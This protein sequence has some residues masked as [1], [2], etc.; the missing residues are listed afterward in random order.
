MQTRKKPT[1]ETASAP[2]RAA[3]KA[4]AKKE[5]SLKAVTGSGKINVDLSPNPAVAANQP[6][7][8][9]TAEAP[10]V[11]KPKSSASPA[12]KIKPT[13]ATETAVEKVSHSPALLHKSA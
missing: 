13:G 6:T 8:G 12:V 10:Q 2:D 1:I 7:Q 4:A 11:E 9:Q 5:V 3:V